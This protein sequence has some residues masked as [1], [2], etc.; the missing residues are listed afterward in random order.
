M[1]FRVHTWPPCLEELTTPDVL[2]VPERP[3]GSA[4][5]ADAARVVGGAVLEQQRR[6]VGRV[7][8]AAARVDAPPVRHVHPPAAE[9]QEWF[10]DLVRGLDPMRGRFQLR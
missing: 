2:D 6:V 1:W 9:T 4:L 5:E 3:V 7:L 10:H 8:G